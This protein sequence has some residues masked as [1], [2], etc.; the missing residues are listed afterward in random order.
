MDISRSIIEGNPRLMQLVWINLITNA[1]RYTN[2]YGTIEIITMNDKQN[3][4]ILVKDTGIGIGKQDIPHLF[5]R[6]YKVDKARTRKDNSTGLGL[7]IVKKIIEIHR[8]T[9]MVE[10]ELG[11]GTV[12]QVTLPRE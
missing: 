6:F 7:S 9:I 2:N 11:K 10:S 4:I 3:V 12:L 1:I 8:G 5:E